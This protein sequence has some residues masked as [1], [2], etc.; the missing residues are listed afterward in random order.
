EAFVS[1][2]VQVSCRDCHG[3]GHLARPGRSPG[4]TGNPS[5]T[6]ATPGWGLSGVALRAPRSSTPVSFHPAAFLRWPPLPLAGRGGGRPASA[7]VG[8]HGRARGLRRGYPAG[9]VAA[10]KKRDRFPCSSV[11]PPAAGPESGPAA[12]LAAADRGAPC[13]PEVTVHWRV[14]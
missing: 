11:V 4:M 7:P 9:R 1:K 3:V 13:C 6:P 14:T 12:R 8:A 5:C 10:S 2:E